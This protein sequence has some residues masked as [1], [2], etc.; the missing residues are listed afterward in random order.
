MVETCELCCG[1]RG[2]A[3]LKDVMCEEFE[4][5]HTRA[6]QEYDRLSALFKDVCWYNFE[7]KCRTWNNPWSITWDGSPIELHGARITVD[8]SRGRAREIGEF[9]LY[10]RGPVRSAPELPPQ[11]ILVELQAA[12]EYLRCTLE[13]STAPHDWAPGGRLYNKLLQTTCVPTDYDRRLQK[14]RETAARISKR[15]VHECNGYNARDAGKH[16]ARRSRHQQRNDVERATQA[17]A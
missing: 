14:A 4:T 17:D 2:H 10:Y 3:R 1:L 11:I 7:T 15:L 12:A 5:E 6:Q 9:P 13:Q 8:T 16:R